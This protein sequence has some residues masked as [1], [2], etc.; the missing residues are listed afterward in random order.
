MSFSPVLCSAV[1]TQSLSRQKWCFAAPR[2]EANKR[3]Q[4]VL[5]LIGAYRTGKR[6][7]VGGQLQAHRHNDFLEIRTSFTAAKKAGQALFPEMIRVQLASESDSKTRAVRL[8]VCTV[9]PSCLQWCHD[10]LPRAQSL[11]LTR[12]SALPSDRKAE[13]D[14]AR[15]PVLLRESGVAPAQLSLES[16][17]HTKVG[18]PRSGVF[19]KMPRTRVETVPP[20]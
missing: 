2:A 12:V 6:F 17:S 10:L 11:K 15:A 9:G 5:P 19:R 1:S 18:R 4:P 8:V 16:C 20:D 14:S 3:L 7:R 13:P